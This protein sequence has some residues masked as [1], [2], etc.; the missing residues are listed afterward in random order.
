M[1]C[2]GVAEQGFQPRLPQGAL[3]L[4]LGVAG[5]R[6]AKPH[7]RGSGRHSEGTRGHWGLRAGER[8]GQTQ[9]RK[10]Y[11]GGRMSQERPDQFVA[12]S[13]GKSISGNH[14]GCL[15]CVLHQLRLAVG[16]WL[17]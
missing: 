3:A 5:W 15:E 12:E 6:L 7:Q 17:T 13:S 16:T 1:P 4:R 11:F 8:Q 14:L 10:G 2:W 9:T